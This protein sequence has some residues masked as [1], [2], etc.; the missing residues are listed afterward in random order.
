MCITHVHTCMLAAYYDVQYVTHTF[1]I[2]NLEAGVAS[3][4]VQGRDLFS[5]AHPKH[6]LTPDAHNSTL[7]MMVINYHLPDLGTRLE[8]LKK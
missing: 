2:S 6:S 5:S 1:M 8:S 3:N 7:L 4:R